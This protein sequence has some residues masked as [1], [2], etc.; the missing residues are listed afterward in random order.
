M[1]NEVTANEILNFVDYVYEFYNEDTG[2][3]KI[4]GFTVLMLVD[5]I[6]IY[7]NS[8][9]GH[10]TW[11]G[12]DSVDRERVRDIVLEQNSNLVFSH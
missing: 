9:N 11:G 5:A 2:T 7:L 4:K 8:L 10:I 3:Y 12:G 1:K 6:K